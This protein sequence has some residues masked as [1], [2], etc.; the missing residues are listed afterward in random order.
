MSRFRPWAFWRRLVYGTG[1]AS[2]WLVVGVVVYFTS[3]YSPAN[4]FDNIQNGGEGGVDCDGQCVRICAVSVIPP[5]V[6][7]VDS[8]K[9]VDGQYNA[10]AYVENKNS[11]A[12]TRDLK[13]TIKLLDQGTLIAEREGVTILPPNS[14]YPIFE[15]RILTEG[16]RAPTETLIEIAEADL[17][18]PATIGRDQFRVLDIDLTNADSRPRLS[19][20]IE[21]TALINAEDVEVV[22]TIFD[23]RGKAV[24]ASQ[25]FIDNFDARSTRE[26]VFTWPNS[27]AK[28]VR[29]CEVPSDIMLVLDRSGSMTADG[30]NPPEPLTSA[31]L[32][33]KAFVNQVKNDNLLGLVSYATTP[34][35]PLE[36]ELTN[37]KS[38]LATAIDEVVMGKDGVQY[39][40]MGD[41]FKVALAELTSAR[42]RPDARKVIIFLT[43]GDVTRPVNPETGLADRDYAA[44]Y[45]EEMA[46][47]A[48]AKDT[49]IYTIGFG[50]FFAGEDASIA[51][52]KE[53]IKNLASEPS[54]YFEAPTVSDL[55]RVYE[56]IASGLCEDGPSR[57]EVITK[58][59]TNFT[60][61]R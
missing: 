45:A 8:F 20:S 11:Q 29:S 41:A 32:A 55:A 38:V 39:T 48:K 1:F 58:T 18:L 17:W 52:D 44:K 22:A 56:Q 5:S 60:P 61:L 42:H 12:S 9:I 57:I 15:G 24:T 4:C 33:A 21:N 47:I 46:S 2:F 19:T 36:Q 37:D 40:N 27:I 50:K 6:V 3:F 49:T 54:L 26:V 43:D 30:V 16:G 34:T 53:L 13:Y 14:V 7:W 31:K 28:T 35:S 25:T 59:S 10:V 51:R 23:A